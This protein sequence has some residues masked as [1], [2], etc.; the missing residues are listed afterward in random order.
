MANCC[1][2]VII[3]QIKIAK[4]FYNKMNIVEAMIFYFKFTEK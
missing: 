2:K 4:Q 3:N 1:K